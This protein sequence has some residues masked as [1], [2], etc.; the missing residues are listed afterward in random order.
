MPIMLFKGKYDSVKA[1]YEYL[2][3]LP[4]SEN[5]KLLQG[6]IIRKLINNCHSGCIEK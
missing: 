3:I 6:N 4:L 2:K 5:M 1:L